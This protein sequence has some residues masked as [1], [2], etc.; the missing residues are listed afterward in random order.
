MARVVRAAFVLVALVAIY[1]VTAGANGVGMPPPSS[2]SMGG[3]R[4]PTPEEMA[5]QAYNS[6][7]DHREKGL[8]AEDKALKATKD[9]DR[10]KEE[11]KA[12]EEYEKAFKDFKKSADLNPNLPQAFNGMG[13]AYRKLGEYAKALEMYDKALQMAP[14][15]PDA[16]EYRGEAYLAVNRLDDAKQAYLTLFAMDRKLADMLMKAMTDYVAKKKADPA[17]V[18]PAALSTFEGWIKERSGIAQQT[19]LMTLNASHGT[20]H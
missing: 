10:V 18:D 4:A 16:I 9:A 20:W 5:V 17:G 2:P 13:F 15:F 3:G 6:G 1:Q 7:F 12:R 19:R 8:K 11:K 14:N